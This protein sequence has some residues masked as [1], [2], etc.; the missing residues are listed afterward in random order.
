MPSP[1]LT[2]GTVT[3]LIRQA[4]EG[5]RSAVEVLMPALYAE[6][7]RIA[8]RSLR[9]ERRGHTLQTTALVHEAYLRLLKDT[10]LSVQN[11]A[12]FLAIAAQSMRQILVEHARA[13]GASKRGGKRARVTLEEAVAPQPAAAVD[14]LALEEA[15]ERLAALDPA[16]A[17]IVEM[18]FYAGMTVEETAAALGTSPATVKRHW[19]MARAWLYRE[20]A[21]TV[22]DSRQSP[23]DP[24]RG[25]PEVVEGPMV[26]GRSSPLDPAR[27]DPELVEGSMARSRPSGRQIS[28][29]RPG[30][31]RHRGRIP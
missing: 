25:D 16:Q 8:A 1:P 10:R 28:P 13:R 24:A 18:R 3:A 22:V 12:H 11:R 14:V 2:P 9:G 29:G 27:G 23:L 6:L 4:R 26:D 20:L 7:R 19:S 5:D 21:S 17:R 31:G 30:P 15:L